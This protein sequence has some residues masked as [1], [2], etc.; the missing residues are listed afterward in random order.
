MSSIVS[1]PQLFSISRGANFLFNTTFKG[2]VLTSLSNISMGSL[3]ESTYVP[4]IP[5]R[6]STYTLANSSN[7]LSSTPVFKFGGEL[8]NKST[9][10]LFDKT[11]TT[12]KNNLPN[13][14]IIKIGQWL[15]I[16]NA[17][18][19]T[20]LGLFSFVNKS[21]ETKVP[22][23][24]Y[25]RSV[26]SSALKNAN[27]TE[28]QS[29]Y[30]ANQTGN[31][32]FGIWTGNESYRLNWKGF[33]NPL[34]NNP[35]TA[36]NS[37]GDVRFLVG[38]FRDHARQAGNL[39]WHPQVGGT[40]TVALNG[41]IIGFVPALVNGV[42][43]WYFVIVARDSN[44]SVLTL[45]HQTNTNLN[46]HS[47]CVLG[48]SIENKGSIEVKAYANN[49]VIASIDLGILNID[50][51]TDTLQAGCSLRSIRGLS[52]NPPYI[53]NEQAM[54][55]LEMVLENNPYIVSNNER[56]P[57]ESSYHNTGLQLLKKLK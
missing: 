20:K 9:M 2:R 16:G 55:T 19:A 5:K 35:P 17:Q 15:F 32:D 38:F 49:Q 47:T 51:E 18:L 29:S 48:V 24:A 3:D 41:F 53:E 27:N 7:L 54:T 37:Y 40:P 33:I 6:T 30:G 56:D 21:V 25:A 22:A 46:A 50:L 10:T 43:T 11:F 23:N 57:A 4:G 45:F 14:P 12:F 42:F 39:A 36:Q 44:T 28:E 1:F 34:V 26:I 31:I 8:T 13:D 52:G